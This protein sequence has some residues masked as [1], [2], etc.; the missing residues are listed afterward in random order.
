MERSAADLCIVLVTA[1]DRDT[2]LRLARGLVAERL[3]ACVNVVPGATSVYRWEGEVHEDGE[4]LLVIKASPRRLDEL[5]R[6]IRAAHPYD[7]PEIV[8]IPTLATHGPYLDWARRETF[9]E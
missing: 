6:R 3:A 2:A 8:A 7:V 9:P 5:E 1:P 4:V